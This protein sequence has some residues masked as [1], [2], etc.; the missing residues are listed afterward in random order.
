MGEFKN[1]TIFP[2]EYYIVNGTALHF[3][4]QSRARQE[5]LP[6]DKSMVTGDVYRYCA[7]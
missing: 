1:V 2:V 5:S 3:T 7:T 4:N 6:I